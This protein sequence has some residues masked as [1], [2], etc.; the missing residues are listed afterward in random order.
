MPDKHFGRVP[1]RH[2]KKL[3]VLMWMESFRQHVLVGWN[4]DATAAA[5]AADTPG[6]VVDFPG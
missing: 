4:C 5:A 2:A 6:V 1:E 3:I